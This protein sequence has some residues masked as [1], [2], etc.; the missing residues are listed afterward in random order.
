MLSYNLNYECVQL[1]ASYVAKITSS[2][3]SKVSQDHI[4]QNAGHFRDFPGLKN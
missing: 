1:Q 4:K 3:T 2:V